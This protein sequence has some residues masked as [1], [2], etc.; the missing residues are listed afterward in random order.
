MSEVDQHLLRLRNEE[1]GYDTR[2][3][4]E[5]EFCNNKVEYYKQ[6]ILDIFN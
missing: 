3:E 6:F 1:P 5:V 2:K 4:N